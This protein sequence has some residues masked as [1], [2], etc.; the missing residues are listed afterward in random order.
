MA[1]VAIDL[2]PSV[3][4]FPTPFLPS[5]IYHQKRSHLRHRD[6]KVA[7][8]LM[9]FTYLPYCS[10]SL[11]HHIGWRTYLFGPTASVLQTG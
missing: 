6:P 9:F 1:L 10:P 7:P 2:L 4:N 8:G 5:V 3:I 11:P